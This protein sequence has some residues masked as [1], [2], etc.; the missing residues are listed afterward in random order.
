MKMNSIGDDTMATIEH[1]AATAS[2]N[3]IIERL[4]KDGAVIVDKVYLR[5]MSLV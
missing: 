2:P 5:M 4:Q 3:E 1:V